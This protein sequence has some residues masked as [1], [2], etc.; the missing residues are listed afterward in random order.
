MRSPR[1]AVATTNASSVSR[2]SLI[3]PSSSTGRNSGSGRPSF[4]NLTSGQDDMNNNIIEQQQQHEKSKANHYA[5]LGQNFVQT[6]AVG[7]VGSS[8]ILSSSRRVAAGHGA[9]PRKLNSSQITKTAT[10]T[11][12]SPAS[13]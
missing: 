9:S 7:G 6:S 5:K 12:E 4:I 3:S 11:P 13:Q 10:T 2:P 8:S 1:I